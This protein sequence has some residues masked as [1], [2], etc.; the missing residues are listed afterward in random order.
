MGTFLAAAVFRL[1][2]LNEIAHDRT[3]FNTK[4]TVRVDPITS[5]NAGIGSDQH[6]QTGNVLHVELAAIDEHARIAIG[7]VSLK[8]PADLHAG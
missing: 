1:S 7:S 2:N 6:I 5:R 8:R 4:I 3:V